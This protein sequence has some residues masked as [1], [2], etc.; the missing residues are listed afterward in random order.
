MFIGIIAEGSGSP[1]PATMVQTRLH[2][3]D[4]NE[5]A[6]SFHSQPYVVYVAENTPP[7]TSLVQRKHPN[8]N[9]KCVVLTD[10]I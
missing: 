9:L 6:P 10:D 5:H 8:D 4:V 3:L 1:A 7:H 2:V